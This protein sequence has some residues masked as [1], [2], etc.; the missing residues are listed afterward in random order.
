MISILKR[1]NQ[2]AKE[3]AIFCQAD[4]NDTALLK[5]GYSLKEIAEY[6]MMY[7]NTVSRVIKELNEKRMGR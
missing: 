2:D 6:L 3:L 7:Y 1:F 5:Y 4:T